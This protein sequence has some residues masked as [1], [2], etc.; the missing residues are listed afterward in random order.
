[1]GRIT[2][3]ELTAD[4]HNELVAERVTAK[5]NGNHE[6]SRKIRAIILLGVNRKKRAE[7][8]E[9]C[10][11]SL[12]AIYLWQQKFRQSG[13]DGLREHY[14]PKRCSLS[15][16]QQIELA[17]VV[18]A[19]PE[20]A[21]FDTG[22]WTAAL[23]GDIIKDRYGVSYSIS[24][25]T[26]LLHRLNFSVQLPQVQLARADPKAQQRWVNK[27]YPA[28]QRRARKEGGVVFF[29]ETSASSSSPVLEPARGPR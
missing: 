28:I 9:I 17:S 19:G 23:I 6:L 20:A 29:S 12:R 21:G 27:T 7:V 25:V 13:V 11:A 16:L 22:T 10:E 8:A 18:N 14:K 26:K 3:F 5:R 1:M 24:A 2:S 15:E 4:Q